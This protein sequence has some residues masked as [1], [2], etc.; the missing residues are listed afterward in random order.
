[1]IWSDETGAATS[2]YGLL[3]AVVCLACVAVAADLAT[4]ISRMLFRVAVKE[5]FGTSISRFFFR[6]AFALSIK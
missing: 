4:K 5:E 2:E 6:A 3:I 1:M